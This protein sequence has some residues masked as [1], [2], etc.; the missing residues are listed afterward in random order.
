M[1]NNSN[2]NKVAVKKKGVVVSKK[3]D[4][5]V[6]VSVDMFKSHPKYRKKF[7][8]TKRYKAHDEENK[9]QVGDVV[10]IKNCRPISKDKKYK[11]I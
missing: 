8:L 9:C 6:I 11:I 1:E 4:K 7:R 2:N 3:G 5:T 10:E